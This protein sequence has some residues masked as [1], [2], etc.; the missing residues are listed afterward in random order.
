MIVLFSWHVNFRSG[1]PKLKSGSVH[2]KRKGFQVL[3][4]LSIHDE[5][6]IALRHANFP[7][8]VFASEFLRMFLA[9]PSKS[10]VFLFNTPTS[11]QTLANCFSPFTT[12]AEGVFLRF[13]SFF[14]GWV[15]SFPIHTSVR[16]GVA[17]SVPVNRVDIWHTPPKEAVFEC[18]LTS[19]AIINENW[20]FA[21]KHDLHDL[22]LFLHFG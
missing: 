17:N 4:V 2:P 18:R 14:G 10:T 16:A 1:D 13:F 19:E 21:M 3:K 7:T 8:A 11:Q 6:A 12:F 5:F 15:F 20:I 22:I 9:K